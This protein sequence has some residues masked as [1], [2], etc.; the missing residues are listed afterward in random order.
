MANKPTQGCFICR[1]RKV[2]CDRTF[3]ECTT[4]RRLGVQC[5]GYDDAGQPGVSSASLKELQP[6]VDRA[7]RASGLERRRAGAC[8]ACHKAKA[9]CSKAQPKCARCMAHD[10]DCIYDSVST[11]TRHKKASKKSGSASADDLG[12]SPAFSLSSSEGANLA[13]FSQ[14]VA[15]PSNMG[16]HVPLDEDAWYVPFV[17]CCTVRR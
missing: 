12:T 13:A 17:N 1:S 2:K 3:P 15:L 11:K 6:L 8:A 5:P 14:R 7:Y 9:R 16:G 10:V 4:C